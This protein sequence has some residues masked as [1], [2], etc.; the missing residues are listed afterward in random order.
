MAAGLVVGIDGSE[1]LRRDR[2]VR[3]PWSAPL[4]AE[5]V[6][7]EPLDAEP[8]DA[9]CR[10]HR[11]RQPTILLLRPY[12]TVKRRCPPVWWGTV[13]D[14]TEIERLGRDP[15]A[16]GGGQPAIL[17]RLVPVERFERGMRSIPRAPKGA[18]D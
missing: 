13:D 11:R 15:D 1:R 18:I 10:R 6:D 5:P 14:T 7:A 16:W 4:D 9:G 2:R 12:E 3:R 17:V 8:L